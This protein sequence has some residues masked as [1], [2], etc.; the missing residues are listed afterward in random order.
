MNSISFNY[1]GRI[2]ASGSNDRTVILWNMDTFKEVFKPIWI[3]YEIHS[4]SF[5]NGNIL[6][7]GL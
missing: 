4:V 7:C 3:G 6:A 5:N 2:L 1:N